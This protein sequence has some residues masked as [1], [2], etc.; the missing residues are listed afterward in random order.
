M[1]TIETVWLAGVTGGGRITT[2]AAEKLAAAMSPRELAKMFGFSYKQVSGGMIGG[3]KS[4]DL[5]F[6]Q[7]QPTAALVIKH[8]LKKWY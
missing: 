5:A 4:A 7:L 6:R 3:N 2:Q 1:A 8:A